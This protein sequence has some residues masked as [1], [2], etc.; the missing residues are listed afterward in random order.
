[1][2]VAT[3]IVMIAPIRAGTLK[4]VC[5]RNNIQTIPAKAP[6]IHQDY[7][8][9]RPRLEIDGHQKVDQNYG[10]D[11]AQAQPV[12]RRVHRLH[13]SSDLDACSARQLL[14][15][16]SNDAVYLVTNPTEIPAIHVGVNVEQRLR[17]V[18]VD[19]SWRY[20]AGDFD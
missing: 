19:N 4:V 20:S 18:V 10:E 9:I 3:P 14:A 11:D 16:P 1:M 15:D 17:V 12:K 5:V 13:L 8:R 7:E 6:G 2:A